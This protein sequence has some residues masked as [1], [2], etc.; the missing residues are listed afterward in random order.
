[1]EGGREGGREGGSLIHYSCVAQD[2]GV[3]KLLCST[4]RSLV[5]MH[6]KFP[7]YVDIHTYS[8]TSQH[9]YVHTYINRLVAD[10]EDAWQ[11][12]PAS[13]N[14]ILLFEVT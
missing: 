7:T 2:A 11:F 8:P 1:M 10:N 4:L 9:T 5:E 3:V 12:S 6:G 13:C 14:T